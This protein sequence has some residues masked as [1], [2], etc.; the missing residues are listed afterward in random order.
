MSHPWEAQSLLVTLLLQQLKTEPLSGPRCKDELGLSMRLTQLRPA[1]AQGRSPC[2]GCN[3]KWTLFWLFKTC[4]FCS[5][6]VLLLLYS[7]FLSFAVKPEVPFNI[8]ITY[9]K[10]ANEYLIHYSTPHSWKKYL[11]DKLI[12]QIAYRQEEGTWKVSDDV[13]VNLHYFLKL[14]IIRN[15]SIR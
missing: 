3:L 15:T 13:L 4:L 8:N 5:N 6:I 7:G 14:N 1:L 12:H 10:E 2:R 9:Q 11:K